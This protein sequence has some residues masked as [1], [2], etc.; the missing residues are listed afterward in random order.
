M[1]HFIHNPP[2]IVHTNRCYLTQWFHHDILVITDVDINDEATL[3]EMINNHPCKNV[4]VDL[5]HN[6]MLES[7]MPEH[8]KKFPTL[9]TM[10][11]TWYDNSLEKTNV[12]YFP[13]WLWMFSNRSNQFFGSTVFDAGGNKTKPIMCLNRNPAPHRVRLRQL[14]DSVV[15]EMVYTLSCQGLPGD[16][17]E[18]HDQKIRID[19]SVG[20]PVYSQ[21]AVNVVTETVVD[22]P[23]L[24]EKSCKPFVARQIPIIVGPRH[25]NRFLSD[26]GL[27][28]FEDLIPWNTWDDETDVETKLQLISN[29][30]I[31]WVQSG[32]IL[33]SYRSVTHR[34]ERNKQYFHSDEFRRTILKRMPV[35]DPFI[36]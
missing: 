34:V 22:R 30:V 16:Y 29:F 4:V 19:I 13:L 17:V 10:F 11:D 12:H 32:T 6:A 2:R 24:S 18:P 28:M 23:S 14:L 27:D 35:I 20:H 25:A 36:P 8:L 3:E 31:S 21:C 1:I 33:P 26:L 7:E 9:S 15:H 5:S